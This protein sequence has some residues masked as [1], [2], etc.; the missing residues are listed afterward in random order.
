[1]TTYAVSMLHPDG[2]TVH[3]AADYGAAIVYVHDPDDIPH[4][5]PWIADRM[6]LRANH[7][8]RADVPTAARIWQVLADPER[9]VPTEHPLANME[10]TR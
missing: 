3:G 6:A 7:T 5:H 4:F 9:A 10:H 8:R 2:S 1:M